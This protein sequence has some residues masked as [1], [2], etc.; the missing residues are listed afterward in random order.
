MA[1]QKLDR[2]Y[3]ALNARQFQELENLMDEI[4]A[5]D[6]VTEYPQ[7]GERIRGRENHLAVLKNYPGLPDATIERVRGAEDKWVLTPSWTPLRITGSGDH[8]TVEGRL[9]YPNGEVWNY[10]DLFELRNDKVVKVTEYFVAPFPAAE[11]RAKWVEKIEPT[12]R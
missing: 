4:A 2:W 11:W 7:S 8:Y 1:R 6:M 3:R 12:G 9:A 5:S 10:V